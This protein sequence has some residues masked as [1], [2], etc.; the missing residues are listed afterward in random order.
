M[1]AIR[2][3]RPSISPDDIERLLFH[4]EDARNYVIKY[5]SAQDF[6]SPE[7]ATAERVIYAV[8]ELALQIT[9][10][11]RYF[12]GETASAGGNEIAFERAQEKLAKRRRLMGLSI[13]LRAIKIQADLG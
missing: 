13:P 7:K 3:Q 2:R 6:N 10:K 4:L 8:D 12:W 5:G 1:N 11:N 9:G